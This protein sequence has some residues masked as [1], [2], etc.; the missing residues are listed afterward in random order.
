MILSAGILAFLALLFILGLKYLELLP[1]TAEKQVAVP[2][3]GEDLKQN[4]LVEDSKE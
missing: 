4:E 1:V 2:A 3:E